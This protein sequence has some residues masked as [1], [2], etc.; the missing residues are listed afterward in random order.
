[1]ASRNDTR[2]FDAWH[3][4]CPTYKF[5]DITLNLDS[6]QNRAK[7][8][9]DRN[10]LI[11]IVKW[12]LHQKEKKLRV[13]RR[14]ISLKRILILIKS[15]EFACWKYFRWARKQDL[16][17]RKFVITGLVFQPFVV[18][19]GD[20]AFI[21]VFFLFVLIFLFC[22]S[23]LFTLN[24]CAAF[25]I[26]RLQLCL[27][28]KKNRFSRWKYSFVLSLHCWSKYIFSLRLIFIIPKMIVPFF[29]SIF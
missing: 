21:N 29:G 3:V 8:Q 6:W 11:L 25:F 14:C 27:N 22:R 5:N 17:E 1:M 13:K 20:Y 12:W 15:R 16:V 10:V 18:A 23:F 19:V 28:C 7:W 26:R 24:I 2:V 4:L 9:I